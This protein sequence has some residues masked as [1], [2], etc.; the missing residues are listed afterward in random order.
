MGNSLLGNSGSLRFPWRVQLGTSASINLSTRVNNTGLDGRLR[1]TWTLKYGINE[2]TCELN[3]TR[4]MGKNG[5]FYQVDFEL[6]D[7]DSYFSSMIARAETNF[8]HI[9]SLCKEY[10]WFESEFGLVKANTTIDHQRGGVT[11]TKVYWYGSG[12]K[13][14]L[15]V[16]ECKKNS[17]KEEHYSVATLAHYFAYYSM[18]GFNGGSEIDIG[19]SVVAK[20]R[21]FNGK[22]DVKVEGPDQHPASSLFEMF[23]EVYKEVKWKPTMCRHCDARGMG[24]NSGGLVMNNYSNYIMAFKRNF[25]Q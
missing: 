12:N 25:Y 15:V 16:L 3:L 8:L 4:I 20:L 23:H 13:R 24:S 17:R 14:G 21:P 22:L 7:N 5:N 18:I 9:S 11:E 6:R 10:G 1:E 2:S 19:L